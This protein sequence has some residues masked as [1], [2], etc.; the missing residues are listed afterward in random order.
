MPNSNEDIRF[1]KFMAWIGWVAF[2][3]LLFMVLT[4]LVTTTQDNTVKT[5]P[6]TRLSRSQAKNT[7]QS[8]DSCAVRLFNII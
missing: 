8:V 4:S 7:K 1:I 3:A 2:V 5:S 6:I